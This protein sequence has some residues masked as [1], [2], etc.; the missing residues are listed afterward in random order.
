MPGIGAIRAT[1]LTAS[2]PSVFIG[3]AAL[4]LSGT[5]LPDQINAGPDLLRRCEAI[6]DPCPRGSDDGIG[7]R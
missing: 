7:G 6:G 4:G 2:N 3:A 1:L 5:E